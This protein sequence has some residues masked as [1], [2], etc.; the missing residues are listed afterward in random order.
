MIVS[1]TAYNGTRTNLWILRKCDNELRRTDKILHMYLALQR[2]LFKMSRYILCNAGRPVVR[3]QY[4]L[5]A[6]SVEKL[7]N[8]CRFIS[9]QSLRMNRM[10]FGIHVFRGF[11]SDL[12]FCGCH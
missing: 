10:T 11:C 1:D 5:R 12:V 9:T 6:D 2:R 7:D 4:R 8:K 3:R